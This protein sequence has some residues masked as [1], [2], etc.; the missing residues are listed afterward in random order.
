MK[1]KLAVAFMIASLCSGLFSTPVSFVHAQADGANNNAAVVSAAAEDSSA[2]ERRLE[3]CLE[4]PFSIN[5]GGCLSRFLYF[6]TWVSAHFARLTGEIFDYF[7]AYSIDSGSYQGTNND[8]V[9]KGWG[10]VRDIANV[11]FIFMLLFM[12]ISHILQIGG[13][14]KKG[15]RNLIIAALLI[16]F[17]LFFTKVIIDAGNI[18]ARAFYHNIEIVNEENPDH[19]SISAGIADKLEPQKLVSSE[20]F[21]PVAAPG[22]EAQYIDSGWA[23]LILA[24]ATFVNITLGLAFLSVFLLFA[25]R[26]IGLWFM[27]IFSPVAFLTVGVPSIGGFFKGMSFS[28]WLNQTMS[29]S[30][31]APIFMFFLFLLVM[32][33]EVVYGTTIPGDQQSSMQKIMAVVV[34]F[35]AVVTI[36]RFAKDQAKTMSGK[37]GEALVGAVGK[38][39]GIAG[40]AALGTVAFAGRRVIGGA[41]SMGLRNGNF[42]ARIAQAQVDAQNATTVT[43]KAAAQ[44]KLR[45]LMATQSRLQKFK[46]SSFDIRNADKSKMLY[47]A[48]GGVAGYLG[49][50][51]IKPTMKDVGGKDLDFGKGSKE[52]RGKFESEKEKEKLKRAEELSA[53]RHNE[54]GEVVE[55]TKQMIRDNI[56]GLKDERITIEEGFKKET[57][58]IT[59][60]L[61][62]LKKK[63]SRTDE[64]LKESIELEKRKAEIPLEMKEALAKNY[65]ETEAQMKELAQKDDYWIKKEQTRRRELYADDVS[66]RDFWGLYMGVDNKE[67]AYNIRKGKASKSDADKLK[68]IVGSMTKKD[69]PESKSPKDDSGGGD[70]EKK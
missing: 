38:I 49:K 6:T 39:A 45:T 44:A 42:E 50:N 29:L 68:E 26:V 58:A 17:S 1:K 28:G 32:F 67:I 3:P 19:K 57:K 51:F 10:V 40:T 18:L 59:D 36:I 47:G 14:I 62:E 69:E 16:N 30:F 21:N 65:D 25:A 54:Y 7:L 66:K 9:E 48:V 34:P 33:L 41:A 60:K 4:A 64:D 52:S 35:I 8:F 5:I 12:A 22:R 24:L 63:D 70:K 53:V 27:I 56:E 13:D 20:L 23:S 37:F 31:M 46:D 61:D 55:A 2:Y 43:G 11:A 15:I